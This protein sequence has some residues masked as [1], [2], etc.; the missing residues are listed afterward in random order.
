MTT[1]RALLHKLARLYNVQ[2]AYYEISGRYRESPPEAILEVLKMLGAPLARVEDAGEAL[3]QR[4]QFLWQRGIEPVVIAWQ[5]RAPTVKVRVESASA[6]APAHYELALENGEHRRGVCQDE[7]RRKPVPCRLEGATYIAR[8]LTIPERLPLGYH[9]LTLAVGKRS[10]QAFLFAAPLK[11]FVAE[12]HRQWGV[13]CP[14]YALGSQQSW[15]SGSFADLE[16]FGSMVAQLGG[17]VV[18]TLPLLAAFLNEIYNPS[19][20]APVSRLFWNE[21]YLD[22]A[23]VPE[24][25]KSSTAQAIANS[26]SFRE[27]LEALRAEPLVQYRPAM[28]LKRRLL[29]ELARSISKAPDQRRARFEEFVTHHSRVEDYAAFR[30]TVERQRKPWREWPGASRD[31]TIGAGDY[32]ADA[33]HYHLY[34]QWLAQEQM[35]ALALNSGG[36]ALYLDFPLGVNLDGYDVWRERE[37]FAIDASGGAPP[38]DFFN[39]GQDWGFPPLHPE[40]LRNQGYAYYVDCVR[41]H[42]AHAG[43][44]R[45]DHV[46]GLHRLY[47]VPR[48]F[49]PTEGV[50]VRYPAE[51]FYAIL[52]LESE[53][54]RTE[55]VGENLGT[56]P[57]YVNAAM[58]RHNIHGMF[59]AQFCVG[60]DRNHALPS[61]I[62]AA[63]VASLNTHDTP[64][65]AGFWQEKDIQDRIELGLLA[66]A[67]ID[68]ER[69]TRAAQREALAAYLQS[70]GWLQE[71][72]QDAAA[73]LR[74]WLCEMARS[75]THLLLVTLEDLWLETAPQNVPGTWEERPNWRRKAK[76]PLE[77]VSSLPSVAE[78]LKAIDLIRKERS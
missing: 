43:L 62:P 60:T 44:L 69:R 23:G 50:Y 63:A 32:D 52:S 71:A 61:S 78:T 17:N 73:V 27:E 45:I 77:S 16:R 1:A 7:Q 31:G 21:F 18:G 22:V 55:I 70:R 38:D 39:K 75:E 41:H 64:T 57:P 12:S 51:E 14:L 67:E 58:E 8:R 5:G 28:A 3:R 59:V 47:W 76:F 9:R 74:A 19:P 66:G 49:S 54:Q 72:T 53:R 42:L 30:A 36:A 20:Y 40:G 6:E 10:F 29:E 35:Q 2:T 37:A 15:G 34:V 4:R 33:K 56:V 65:F 48:G 68:R 24:L 11:A 26:S 46:M 25:Q 13:F